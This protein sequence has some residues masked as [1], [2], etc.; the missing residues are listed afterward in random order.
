L[1][2]AGVPA[3]WNA[4]VALAAVG[5]VTAQAI[6]AAGWP[7]AIEADEA[8]TASLVAALERYFAAATPEN[9]SASA[10]RYK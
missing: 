4:R 7:L 1:A 2:G 8:T 5:P 6:R 10:R 9:K 3:G